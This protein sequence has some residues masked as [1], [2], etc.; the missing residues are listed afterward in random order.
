MCAKLI[1]V[2]LKL[3]DRKVLDR[4]WW[5]HNFKK[6]FS[7]L[8]SLIKTENKLGTVVHTCNRSTPET[9]TEASGV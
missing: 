2:Q 6:I 8:S 4:L 1:I 7:L 3:I 5:W 9:E